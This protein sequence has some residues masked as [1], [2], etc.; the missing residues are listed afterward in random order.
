MARRTAMACCMSQTPFTA[1]DELDEQGLRLHLRRMA[2]AGVAVY[3]ASPGSGEGHAL[4]DAELRRVYAI[5]VEE[6][7][8]KVPVYANPPEARTGA[9]MAGRIRAAVEAGVDEVQIYPVDN[10]HGMKPTTAEQDAYYRDLLDGFDYPTAISVTTMANHITPIPL[11]KALCRDYPQ[12]VTVNVIGTPVNY[13]AEIMDELGP[14]IAFYNSIR[15]LADGLALGTSGALLGHANLVPR[16]CRSVFDRFAAS[17][18]RKFSEAY[19]NL[20][21]LN[22]IVERWGT[23]PRW[24]KM[25]M[26]V[27]E[28]PGCGDGRV[29]K[30][31]LSPPAA[32]MADM[33]KAFD[34]MGLRQIEG[35]GDERN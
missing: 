19:T 32:D 18:M 11:L 23:N 34:A 10:G 14:G 13:L 16:L 3:L 20:M 17:D 9:Q 4:S 21:R 30:P 25:G 28:L 2:E 29:R 33:A 12:I 1:D 27:L 5:G 26:K 7:K 31:Y 15:G 6:C 35:L 8:G 24:I 22:R